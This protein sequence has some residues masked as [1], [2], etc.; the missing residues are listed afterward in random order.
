ML[1]SARENP[2]EIAARIAVA[3]GHGAAVPSGSG[4]VQVVISRFLNVRGKLR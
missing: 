4:F 3:T 1:E 2:A